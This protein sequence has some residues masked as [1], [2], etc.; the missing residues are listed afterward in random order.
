ME[1]PFDIILAEIRDL[2]AQVDSLAAGN[3]RGQHTQQAG[4]VRWAAA[5]LGVSESTVRRQVQLGALAHSRPNGRDLLFTAADLDAY[6]QRGRTPTTDDEVRRAMAGH[7][8]H[9]A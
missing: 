6:R 4:D 7:K 2:R 9:R 1:N 8:R 5:Q 3:G